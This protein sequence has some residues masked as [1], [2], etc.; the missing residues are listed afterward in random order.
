MLSLFRALR[1]RRIRLG[2]GTVGVAVAIIVVSVVGALERRLGVIAGQHG[3]QHFY[4]GVFQLLD[5]G[6]HGLGRGVAGTNNKQSTVH[7]IA[8]DRRVCH[9]GDGRRVEDDIIKSGA[10]LLD[11]LLHP[12]RAQ[13]LRGVR[14]GRAGGQERDLELFQPQQSLFQ[15]AL[16][17]DNIGNAFHVVTGFQVF[18]QHGL[19]QVAVHQGYIFAVFGQGQGQVD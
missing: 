19:A 11:H 1:C 3:T 15:L 9:H 14:R 18:V 12:G 5:S 2:G 4:A 17:G 16:V 8:D 10:Q 7:L 13:Q 6:L